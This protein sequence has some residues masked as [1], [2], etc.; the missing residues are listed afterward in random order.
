MIG[1][2]EPLDWVKG[3]ATG[4][5]IPTHPQALWR[6]GAA[7]LTTAFRRLGV[8]EADNAVRRIVEM[9]PCPGGSTGA[10]VFLTLEYTQ[11]ATGL[12]EKLFAKFSRDFADR[13]R[14]D[15]GKF[16]MAG[17][18]AMAG[19]ARSAD[20]PI[21]VPRAYFADIEQASNTGLLIT[22]CIAFGEDGLEPHHEKCLDHRIPDPLDHYRAIVTALARL[23]GA[24]RSGRLPAET[25]RLFPY[26]A[27]IA[28][29]TIP[30]GYTVRDLRERVRAFAE[31]VGGMPQLFPE[32]LRHRE[33]FEEIQSGVGLFVRNEADIN[34]FLQ[35]DPDY[36]ALCHWNANIDNAYF[37]RRPDGALECGLMD[38]GRAGRMNVAFA[39]WGALCAAHHDIWEHHM[40]SL[41]GLFADTFAAEGGPR[42]KP[43]GLRL[44]LELYASIMGLA[45]FLDSPGRIRDH[46]PDLLT[47][48]GPRDPALLSSE[49]ARNQLHISTVVLMLW[50]RRG[51]GELLR[52]MPQDDSGRYS[53]LSHSG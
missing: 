15:R 31:F 52:Q 12:H 48:E 10:K 35:G 36:I 43:E 46:V 45:Y 5:D 29:A 11:P 23:A 3:D 17:E 40:D 9:R 20:F 34:R 1:I 50:R 13:V 33:F 19:L 39:L 32:H 53:G 24:H 22:E 30:I 4:L 41:L 47:V 8:L 38:W 26:D 51:L 21:R 42:L 14:D 2:R 37:W 25:D 18:I 7:F 27:R 16:E 44:H 6:A 49:R 28:A